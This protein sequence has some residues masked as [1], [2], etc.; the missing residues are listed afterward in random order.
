M[1]NRN[2]K[3]GSSCFFMQNLL[4]F[5]IM[6]QEKKERKGDKSR[7]IEQKGRTKNSKSVQKRKILS[8]EKNN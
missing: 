3:Q 6:Q 1:K 5:C 7:I 8:I 2:C 4:I